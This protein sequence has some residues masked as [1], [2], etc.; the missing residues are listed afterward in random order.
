MKK[1]L[2]SFACIALM[3]SCS[4]ENVTGTGG[5]SPY[6]KGDDTFTYTYDMARELA[7]RA[8]SY[9]STEQTK[10]PEKSIAKGEVVLSDHITKSGSTD[11]LMYIFN[12]ADDQGYVV[13][14]KEDSKGGIL[15]YVDNGSLS[16][17][18]A[19]K[20][21]SYLLD[22]MKSYC[23]SDYKIEIQ[24]KAANDY[25]YSYK[26]YA[27]VFIYQAGPNCR[28]VRPA[29]TYD[30]Y[31]EDL[32]VISPSQDTPFRQNGCI[33]NLHYETFG[34]GVDPLLTTSWGQG[35]P[36]NEKAPTTYGDEHMLA[37]SEAAAFAQLLAYFNKP[38]YYPQ[39]SYA[40]GVDVSGRETRIGSLRNTRY[41]PSGPGF[42]DHVSTLYNVIGNKFQNSWDMNY[43]YARGQIGT[44]LRFFGFDSQI[45]TYPYN[46]GQVIES[47]NINSP[48][49]AIG[50]NAG[51]EGN[52]KH[53]WVID[54]WRQ[55]Y[56]GY[57]PF[58]FNPDGS[59]ACKGDDT[60]LDLA[61]LY[62]LNCNFGFDGH[63]NGFYLDGIFD[64]DR[65]LTETKSDFSRNVMITPRMY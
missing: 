8:P 63:S 57:T 4:K 41:G 17:T 14:S 22:R 19:G 28:N 18:E 27:D 29:G 44:V 13:I 12:Y 36:F 10:S 58:Y 40:N 2:L 15:A 59:L 53:A 20:L 24:T 16:A 32:P 31:N 55:L 52:D 46:L 38:L 39:G 33:A 21:D 64:T 30:V 61:W 9:F 23:E 35:Y 42:R 50:V 60:Y 6:V 45:L 43:T 1:I 65:C 5:E 3:L 34:V 62:Y 54:G 26:K 48:V 49:Y 7:L 47:I 25:E 11:T 51:S 56:K 37:G